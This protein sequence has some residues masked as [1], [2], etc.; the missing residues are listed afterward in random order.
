MLSA[1]ATLVL[2]VVACG[3]PEE[4]S[5]PPRAADVA[6]D[7][8]TEV[9]E[10]ERAFAAA[11]REGSRKGAFLRFLD[12]AGVLFRPGPVEGRPALEAGPEFP[13]LLEWTPAVAAVSDDGELGFTTGP[14]ILTV[15]D[16]VGTGRYT[17]LW[18]RTVEGEY[19]FVLDVGVV[20]PG[21]AVLPTDAPVR[22][23]RV[24]SP[25]PGAGSRTLMAADSAVRA[26]Y[27]EGA[28][29]LAGLAFPSWLQVLRPGREPESGPAPFLAEVVG[30]ADRGGVDWEV[31]GS[32][33]SPDGSL[34]YVYG[35]ASWASGTDVP[36]APF[37]RIWA[38]EDD[39]DWQLLLDLLGLP[40]A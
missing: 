19:R 20:G 30:A 17:T 12:S 23:A 28:P 31:A 9:V 36:A 2:A 8:W 16:D 1:T 10:T 40:D 11:A 26:G 32:G 15:G 27:T 4:R 35:M 29:A 39:G 3:P 25:E 21:P 34:G 38:R 7:P 13:G 18:R 24:G 14:W 37:L 22:R 6:D 5:A 33:A